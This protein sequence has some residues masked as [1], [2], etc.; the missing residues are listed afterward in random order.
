MKQRS[1]M[2]HNFSQIPSV[3]IP[4]SSFDRS[5]GLKTTLDSGYL[6]PIFIDDVIPGDSHNLHMTGFARMATPLKPVMDNLYLETFFFFVPYRLVWDNWV[7]M[8]GEQ[9][10]PDDTIDFTVPQFTNAGG[11]SEGSLHD[12]MGVPPGVSNLPFSNLPARAYN[13]IYNEWFRSENLQDSVTVDKDNAAGSIA[14]YVLL[15]RNKR[16]DYFTSAL[17]WPQKFDSPLLPLGDSAP[18]TGSGAP[19]F[20]VNGTYQTLKGETA[21]TVVEPNFHGSA[22]IGSVG[23]WDA[24][25][26]VTN[27]SADLSSATSATI[28]QIRQAFQIQRL[29][30]RDARG[31]TRYTEIIRSHFGVISPDAR[32]QRPE[33]L[34]GGR[35]PIN[36]YPVANQTDNS[37]NNTPF[38]SLSAYATSVVSDHTFNKSFTEHGII[39]GLANVRA[40]LTYQQGLDRYFSK[41]TRYDFYYPSL[42]H[43]G[44]QAILN[45][46]IYAQGTSADD[47]V[48]GYQERFAEYRYK[49]SRICGKFRSDATNSLD[50]WHLSQDFASLPTLGDTF[51]QDNP[52]VDRVIAVT[53][54]PEFILDCYFKLRSAR[55]MPMYGVPGFIDHF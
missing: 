18:V 38:G 22:T 37:V 51:I 33:Y 13:L 29:L 44:E 21:S 35:S 3:S 27:L 24:N 46:E 6:V 9:T 30:E 2:A 55:P 4:R 48:F 23:D 15:R 26:H 17:P 39:I 11:V 40:D 1:V 8:H 45:K 12:Y 28:N 32:L 25:W 54:E 16:H 47:D 36:F 43:L 53:N 14:N 7:K 34:G 50:V 10:D 41:E 49:P 5:H 19:V 52:P 31:G 20:S 42:A